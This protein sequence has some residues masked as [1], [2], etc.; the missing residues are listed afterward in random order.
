MTEKK[1]SAFVQFRGIVKRFGD[2]TAVEKMDLDVAEGHFVTLLGPSGC[3]KT[4]LLRMLAGLETPTE[5][6][7]FIKGKRINDTPVHKRNLGMIFQNYALFPHKT[8]FDNVAFGLKY[9]NIPK[10]SIKEK[11]SNA[12]EM[13]RLPGVEHR[14]PSQLSGG[15]QQRIALARAIVIEPDVLLMDEPL[16]AL[17]ENLREEMRRE[18]DNLQQKLGITTIFVTHDQR[19]ALCMSDKIV[20][21]RD[22]KKLQEGTPQEVYNYSANHFVADFLGHSNF[23]NATVQETGDTRVKVVLEDGKVMFANPAGDFPIGDKAEIVVRAQK[24]TI[25]LRADFEEEENMNIFFGKIIDR[26]YMGGEVSYFVE[27]EN[28]QVLHVINLVDRVPLRIGNEVFIKADPE[29]CRLL[30][31]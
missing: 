10:D 29:Y 20:V 4:T 12:L 28:R 16:S 30:K 31:S 1:D 15:Q 14:K 21:M 19:E 7:M 18:I 25:G 5:G 23:M 3:G 24:L 22:G 13:V 17:D 27:I 6:E 11:V 26:S 9:R 2:V 8:I